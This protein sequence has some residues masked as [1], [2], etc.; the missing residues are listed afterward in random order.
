MNNCR[1]RRLR[2][3]HVFD[4]LLAGYENERGTF[5]G[6][7]RNTLGQPIAPREIKANIIQVRGFQTPAGDFS[8]T[9][10]PRRH[11][12]CDG[13]SVRSPDHM[14]RIAKALA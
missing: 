3:R 6:V 12:A 14:R 10:A 9:K 2:E 5:L 4:L 11:V 1:H 8:D 7:R 13:D